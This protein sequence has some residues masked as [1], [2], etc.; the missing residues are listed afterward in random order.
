MTIQELLDI[1]I[2]VIQA[3]MAGVQ[4][5]APALAVSNAGGLG[6]LPCAL[7]GGDAIRD[8]IQMISASTSRPYNVNF[9]C[10]N[11]PERDAAA[12]ANWRRRLKPYYEEL[13][14]DADAITEGPQRTPFSVE[15]L[16]TIEEF[17]PPVVSFHFGLPSKQL[18]DGVK[19]W[20]P[21]VLASAT[22]VEEALWLEAHGV[23][24]IIAQGY[25]AGG[26]RGIF[27]PGRVETQPAAAV[28]TERLAAECM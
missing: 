13:G 26:H 25:E 20:R 7:L 12:E 4:T 17:K 10:H 27:L 16:D 18:M 2:P 23:D 22:T 11:V 6:S 8:E 19:S 14:L 9:F 1:E 5:S 24:A 28:A 15:V 3:P 21:V